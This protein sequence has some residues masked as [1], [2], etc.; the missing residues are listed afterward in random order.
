MFLEDYTIALIAI[1]HHDNFPS[2]IFALPFTTLFETGFNFHKWRNESVHL[3]QVRLNVKIF[4]FRKA[5]I[6]RKSCA[7]RAC[8][9]SRPACGRDSRNLLGRILLR[10]RRVQ[11]VPRPSLRLQLSFSASVSDIHAILTR[12][13][14]VGARRPLDALVALPPLAPLP[15]PLVHLGQVLHR[16]VPDPR[17][18][19]IVVIVVVGHAVTVQSPRRFLV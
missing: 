2:Y 1:N 10:T 11:C 16:L 9:V 4:F 13:A 14:F 19:H 5:K 7:I 3:L 12:L 8:G 17:H 15:P 6:G 18:N